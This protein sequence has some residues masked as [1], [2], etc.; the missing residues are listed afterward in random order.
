MACLLRAYCVRTRVST[1]AACMRAFMRA[2]ILLQCSVRANELK[3]I[4][5]T[6][7]WMDGWTDGR[8]DGWMDGWM[9]G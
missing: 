2:S 4:T 9:D 1:C 6:D 7:G 3:R 5:S 8:M